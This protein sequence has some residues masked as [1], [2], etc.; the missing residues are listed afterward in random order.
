MN[1]EC[2]REAHY[3]VLQDTKMISA[4]C[5]LPVFNVSTTIYT[6]NKDFYQRFIIRHM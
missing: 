4:S 2:I 3:P 6:P 5:L 1:E